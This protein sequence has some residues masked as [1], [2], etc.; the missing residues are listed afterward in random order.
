MAEVEKTSRPCFPPLP[1]MDDADDEQKN[2]ENFLSFFNSPGLL[3]A[4]HKLLEI[5]VALEVGQAC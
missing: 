3:E 2:K 5:L 1:L 4:R